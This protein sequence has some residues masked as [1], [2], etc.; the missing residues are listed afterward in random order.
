MIVIGYTINSAQQ[1]DDTII[2]TPLIYYL[3]N[4]ISLKIMKNVNSKMVAHI[5]HKKNS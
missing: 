4:K 1:I 2:Q 3:H 5:I